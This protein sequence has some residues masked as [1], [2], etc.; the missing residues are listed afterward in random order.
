MSTMVKAIKHT[1][2]KYDADLQFTQFFGGSLY[3]VMMQLSQG[4]G[5]ADV[6]AG[7]SP[8]YVQL[9]PKDAYLV[10]VHLTEW[11]KAVA[12]DK[13][14]HIKT[15]IANNKQLQT[16]ILSEAAEMGKFISD[17]EILNVPM[18]VLGLV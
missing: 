7:D 4:L 8:G 16:T 13:A 12:V 9:T 6:G 11:L 18:A 1:G 3:G 10:I 2:G 17:L 14:E 15:E 5:G